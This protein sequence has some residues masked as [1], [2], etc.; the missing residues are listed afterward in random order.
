MVNG[1][2]PLYLTVLAALL[3]GGATFL[4]QP[5]S[6]DFPGTAYAKPARRYLDAAIRQ[7]SVSL[8]RLS[9]SGAPVAWALEVA[10]LH[11]D[12]LAAWSGRTQAWT[13]VRHGDTTDVLVFPAGDP[14][15]EMPIVLSFVGAGDDARVVKASSQCFDPAR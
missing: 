10:H 1:K 6:V 4:I 11:R 15:S 3:L 7:D 13:G 5:Y 12:S 14:C 2:A 8:T 9:A